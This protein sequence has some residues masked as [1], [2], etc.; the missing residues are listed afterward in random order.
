MGNFYEELFLLVL[1]RTELQVSLRNFENSALGCSVTQQYLA[2]D[3]F[4]FEEEYPFPPLIDDHAQCSVAEMESGDY[5][6]HEAF[7]SEWSNHTFMSSSFQL[8]SKRNS[9][10]S[11][12]DDSFDVD[13][14]QPA[15]LFLGEEDKKWLCSLSELERETILAKR[16]EM[17][18]SEH[19]M[20][21]ALRNASVPVTDEVSD[22]LPS[23]INADRNAFIPIMTEVNQEKQVIDVPSEGIDMT[24]VN[25]DK[26]VTY[27]PSEGDDMDCNVA[28]MTLVENT[29]LVPDPSRVSV[30]GRGRP[31]RCGASS[32]GR[33]N[34]GR[35]AHR[36]R[37]RDSSSSR[38]HG[39]RGRGAGQDA[40]V[41]TKICDS[42]GVEPQIYM[43]NKES[44]LD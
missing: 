14:I 2:M 9:E 5:A 34:R 11:V 42:V 10:L 31:P 35:T 41:G 8:K 18:C 15:S 40:T 27:V 13:N 30:R 29:V 17:L 20:R 39:R 38:G 3:D 44:S 4:D 19:L 26:Q 37:G 33:G 22:K 16:V 43:Y 7:E 6:Y 25:K 32:R 12:D 23:Q 1:P 24:E 28:G 36:S 21:N